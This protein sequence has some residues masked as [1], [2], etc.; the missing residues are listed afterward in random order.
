MDC[1]IIQTGS[2]ETSEWKRKENDRTSDIS[3]A[4]DSMKTGRSQNSS[5]G[6]RLGHSVPNSQKLPPTLAKCSTPDKK[7][8]GPATDSTRASRPAGE[9]RCGPTDNNVGRSSSKP[10][11]ACPSAPDTL[12]PLPNRSVSGKK[13]CSNCGQPLG[14]GAAMI[15]ETL[16]LY[17][18]IHCF[19][20]GA[21]YRF[22]PLCFLPAEA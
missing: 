16:S 18:H 7:Q 2:P 14:K 9:R 13:L 1:F 19:K 21:P 5:Q 22:K 15:I 17:F 10:P 4:D 11:A 20:V 6:E 8:P 12:P 3:T